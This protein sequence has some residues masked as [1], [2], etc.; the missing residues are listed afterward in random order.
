MKNV[1]KAKWPRVIPKAA[2]LLKLLQAKICYLSFKGTNEAAKKLVKMYS[3]NIVLRY[4]AIHKIIAQTRKAL[5]NCKSILKNNNRKLNL[6][7]QSKKTESRLSPNLKINFI[8]I[9][10]AKGP[11]KKLKIKKILDRILQ[12]QLCLLLDP[13]YEAK[14]P[15]NMYAFRKGRSAHQILSFLKT[16]FEKSKNSYAQ[17]TL[18]G[19][20]KYFYNTLQSTIFTYFKVPSK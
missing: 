17:L 5:S 20:R 3:M 18:L 10:K 14:Y 7:F 8:N 15:E 11:T 6:L 1:R 4:F 12:T 9:I 19:I 2:Q 16:I 13:F